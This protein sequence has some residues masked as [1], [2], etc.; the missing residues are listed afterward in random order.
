MDILQ[1]AT[2]VYKRM[3]AIKYTIIVGK[4]GRLLAYQLGF[5]KQNY[6]HLFGLHKIKDI[7]DIYQRASYHLFNAVISGKLTVDDICMSSEYH[8]IVNR[9]ENLIYLEKHLDNMKDFILWDVKKSPISTV[10]ADILLTSPLSVNDNEETFVFFFKEEDKSSLP[11][12]FDVKEFTR[13]TAYSSFSDKLD[14]RK[15]QARPLT[16]MYI[17]K[18]NEE[19]NER[20]IILDHLSD[21]KNANFQ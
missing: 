18:F 1:E 3:L 13:V 4:K 21:Q 12:D 5:D 9:L 11:L 10:D 7:P 15:G 2:A 20:S 6:K 16:I 17:D 19:N 14:Y 8:K